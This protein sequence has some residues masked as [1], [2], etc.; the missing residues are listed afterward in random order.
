MPA[1]PYM[2]V[3]DASAALKFYEDVLGANVFYAVEDKTDGRIVHARFQIE[4]AVVMLHQYNPGEVPG[5]APP[6]MLGANS[7]SI[8]LLP[9]SKQ[10]IDDI[11]AR[12]ENSCTEVISM[13]TNAPWNEYYG[14]LR[15]PFGHSRAFGPPIG[16]DDRAP[17]SG[18]GRN[19]G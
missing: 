15:N 2:A 4:D 13:P 17:I 10:L 6:G 3:G 9:G 1:Y 5:I 14:R 12:V 16:Q 8:R 7:V 19:D 11:F 18:E